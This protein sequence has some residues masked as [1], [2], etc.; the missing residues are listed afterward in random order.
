MP[1]S[2]GENLAHRAIKANLTNLKCAKCGKVPAKRALKRDRR[3]KTRS[4]YICTST[5]THTH[6]HTS[7]RKEA[8]AKEMKKQKPKQNGAKKV[9]NN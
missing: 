4:A 5:R 7:E 2:N 9:F 8:K 1:K 3:S 6:T